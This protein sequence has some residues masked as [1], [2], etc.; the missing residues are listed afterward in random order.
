MVQGVADYGT[1]AAVLAPVWVEERA[2]A[3]QRFSGHARVPEVWE[4]HGL[5]EKQAVR[6]PLEFAWHGTRRT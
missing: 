4:E 2:V 5:D 6:L 1:K 3:R